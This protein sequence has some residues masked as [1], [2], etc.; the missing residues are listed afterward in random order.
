MIQTYLSIQKFPS[1]SQ[2]AVDVDHGCVIE[3]LYDY[4]PLLHEEWRNAVRPKLRIEDR[5]FFIEGI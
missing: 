3:P 1:L 5:G 4:S 2:H